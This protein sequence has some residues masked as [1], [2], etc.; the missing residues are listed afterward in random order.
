MN[1]IIVAIW[2]AAVVVFVLVMLAL[3][4]GDRKIHRC[5]DAISTN[6]RNNP[7]GVEPPNAAVR[8]KAYDQQSVTFDPDALRRGYGI[9]GRL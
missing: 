4:S 1:P 7:G 5:R 2:C 9:G 6:P 3:S 8:G